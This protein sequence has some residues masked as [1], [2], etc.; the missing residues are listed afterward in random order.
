MLPKYQLEFNCNY[1]LNLKLIINNYTSRLPCLKYTCIKQ[2]QKEY[3]RG[4]HDPGWYAIIIHNTMQRW[5]TCFLSHCSVSEVGLEP[6]ATRQTEAGGWLT[7]LDY[8]LKGRLC[9]RLTTLL[10]KDK[11][12][13]CLHWRAT[14][15]EQSRK[16]TILFLM[17]PLILYVMF[18]F[19]SQEEHNKG[20]W[21]MRERKEG[22]G[23]GSLYSV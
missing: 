3:I 20:K 11:F 10:A 1:F 19:L 5:P 13:G 8:W 16:K 4:F 23:G 6:V 21:T 9:D 15:T 2:W 14:D 7:L 22:G 17:R 18:F 12:I